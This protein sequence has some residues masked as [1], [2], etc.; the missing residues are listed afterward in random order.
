MDGLRERIA[1]GWRWTKAALTPSPLAWIAAATALFALWAVVLLALTFNDIIPEFTVEKLL[2]GVIIIGAMA[3][4]S[5][6]LLLI[7]WFLK[8]LRLAYRIALFLALPSLALLFL[9]VW[10]EG[11]FIALPA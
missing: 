4:V 11:M 2:G 6:V 3:L 5:G 9:A 8:S 10:A 7:V 1:A